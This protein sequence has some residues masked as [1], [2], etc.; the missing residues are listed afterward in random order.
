[1]SAVK[2]NAVGDLSEM[3]EGS[4]AES[5][6]VEVSTETIGTT[7]AVTGN[8]QSAITTILPSDKNAIAVESQ[9]EIIATVIVQMTGG[10]NVVSKG[11]DGSSETIVPTTAC[12]AIGIALSATTTT[13]L[14][15]LS[16]TNV[17]LR[18]PEA[19]GALHG[20]MIG[21]GTTDLEETT[22][23]VVT[24][25][26]TTDLEETTDEVATGE[27]TTVEAAVKYSMTMTG[28]AHNAIIPISHSDTNATDVV[29]REMVANQNLVEMTDVEATEEVAMTGGVVTEEVAMTGGVATEEVAMT[30][31]LLGANLVN[32]E[33]PVARV[34]AMLTTDHLVI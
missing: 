24:E 18:S 9:E 22:E 34:L 8:V 21:E 10:S 6:E 1:M 19:K 30:G 32:S 17:V 13:L 27:E 29:Y 14:G 26:G 4:N 7:M 33:R 2:M 20:G 31:D 23:G 5:N 25:E 12:K 15:E 11:V 3:T 16:A 28:S